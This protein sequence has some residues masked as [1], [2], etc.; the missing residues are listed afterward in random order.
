MH[1]VVHEQYEL[2]VVKIYANQKEITNSIIEPTPQGYP[3]SRF[4]K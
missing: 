1:K 3:R 4:T 2:L